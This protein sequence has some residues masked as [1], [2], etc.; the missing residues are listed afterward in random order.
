MSVSLLL[1]HL[2]WRAVDS[3]IATMANIARST[4]LR[5]Y[6]DILREHRFALPPQ[7]RELGDRYVRQVRS[8]FA[9][10]KGYRTARTTAVVHTVVVVVV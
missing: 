6:R 9:S 7:H 5:L 3:I 4:V 1:C 10:S 2:A 8:A